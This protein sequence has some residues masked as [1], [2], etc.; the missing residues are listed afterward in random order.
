MKYVRHLS[1]VLPVISISRCCSDIPLVL[2]VN[3]PA[4]VSFTLWI[5]RVICLTAA[6]EEISTLPDTEHEQNQP[7]RSSGSSKGDERN[8]SKPL[9]VMPVFPSTRTTM[10]S[11]WYHTRLPP[12]GSPQSNRTFS[13]GFLTTTLPSAGSARSTDKKKAAKFHKSRVLKQND[14]P[15]TSHFEMLNI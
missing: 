3:I 7:R 9:W 2:Q 15:M 14:E 5:S 4:S 11:W 8:R 13:P 12:A 10:L 1:G 6:L